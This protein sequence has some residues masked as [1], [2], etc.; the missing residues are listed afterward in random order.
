[1]EQSLL[2]ELIRTLDS[3]EKA[4]LLQF[5]ALPFFN[6]GR[7]REHTLP[8]LNIC[9]DHPW[10]LPEQRLE[11]KDV[12]AKIFP[13]Q[14]FVEGKI[15][16]VMVD[17][18]KIVRSFLLSKHYF[19]DENQFD[20]TL[21][22][23]HIVRSRGLANRQ[24]H[25]LTRAQKIQ[26]ETPVKNAAFFYRQFLL[27]YAIHDLE[28]FQNQKK[29]ELNIS[30]VLNALEAHFHLNRFALLN[31]LLVQQKAT[32]I[33]LSNTVQKLLKESYALDHPFE[34]YPAIKANFEVLNLLRKETIDPEDLRNLFNYIKKEEIALDK[35]SLQEFYSYLR[36]LC[37]LTLSSDV[38]QPKVDYIEMV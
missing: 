25:L 9:L 15:E 32:N 36:S 23:S 4:H 11:K 5:A 3:S 2:I 20:Q 29:G 31:R 38:E 10:H 19:S 37:I 18:L 22:F 33:P 12:Y 30:K 17:A 7:M 28:S 1:M 26:E 8:F 27:E 21:E 35:E 34:E 6:N 13:G 24:L 14:K 16:K